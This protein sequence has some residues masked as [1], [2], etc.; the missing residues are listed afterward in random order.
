MRFP[1]K[2]VVKADFTTKM[3]GHSRDWAFRCSQ[4][5]A[6]RQKWRPEPK[7]LSDSIYFAKRFRLGR[8]KD[9]MT[10]S[11][12][13]SSDKFS[14]ETTGQ[15]MCVSCFIRWSI[16]TSN[17][18]FQE[19]QSRSC[20]ETE[21]R[22]VIPSHVVDVRMVPSNNHAERQPSHKATLYCPNCTHESLVNGDWIIHIHSNHLDYECP[23]CG[24]M[25]ESHSDGPDV[26][27]PA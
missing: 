24:D 19:R 2:A 25:L 9:Y 8:K 13:S 26:I 4:F 14:C 20:I 10:L 5:S 22:T 6:P 7:E 18:S 27:T 15:L 12:S 11:R 16:K 23:E 1:S 3:V 21:N 17:S